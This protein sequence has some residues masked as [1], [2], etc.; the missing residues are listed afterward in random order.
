MISDSHDIPFMDLFVI[1]VCITNRVRY[2]SGLHILD[3]FKHS[4]FILGSAQLCIIINHSRDS[5]RNRLC[6]DHY[7]MLVRGKIP[8]LIRCHHDILI[9]RKNK[10][11]IGIDMFN[12]CQHIIRTRIHG[13]AALDDIIHTQLTEDLIQTFTDGNCDKS[14]RFARFLCRFF[15]CFLSLCLC[16]LLGILDKLLLMFLTHIVD[17]HSGELSECQCFL[18]RKSRI[19]GVY[20]N[21]D[22]IIVSHTDDGIANGFQISLESDLV[23]IRKFFFQQNDEFGTIPELDLSRCISGNPGHIHAASR[24][25]R[26]V[27]DLF[28]EKCIVCSADHFQKSLSAGIHNACFLQ[29]RQHL[30]CLLKNNFRFF[31]NFRNKYLQIIRL[32]GHLFRLLR[33]SS[34]HGKNRSLLRLHNRLIS[35]FLCTSQRFCKRRNI[36]LLLITDRFRKSTEKLGQDNTGV[37]S[38]SS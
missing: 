18:D 15:L 24:F 12:R 9:I 29:N 17:L 28:S 31:D 32:F 25:D 27:F 3:L 33:D 2:L 10:D 8:R 16:K 37:T 11:R 19:I 26:F 1:N 20:V 30:R 34:C 14:N 35:S 21:L 23:L 5:L 7:N 6:R 36:D 38:C 22:N 4:L 13:L